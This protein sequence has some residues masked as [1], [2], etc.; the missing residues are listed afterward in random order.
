MAN[1]TSP[2]ADGPHRPYAISA[3][4]G[5]ASEP[6]TH[7]ELSLPRRCVDVWQ[8]RR[9]LTKERAPCRVV[10]GVDAGVRRAEVRA[11]EDVE[12][13]RD[14]LSSVG[15][16]TERLREPQVDIGKSRAVDGRNR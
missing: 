5:R 7:G 13:L 6:Y 1:G 4:T 14:E 12:Q 9:A 15:A 8:Q 2:T 11:V 10:A 16:D 3:M